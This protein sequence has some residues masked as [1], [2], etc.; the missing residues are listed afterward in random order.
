VGQGRTYLLV[1]GENVDATLG[2]S[3]LG[4]RPAADER[5]RWD[6]VLAYAKSIWEQP[7]TAL[8]FLNA[9]S[10][11]LPLG[12][13]QALLAMGYRPIPLSGG[14]H[15]KV[16]DIGIQRTLTAILER[17]GQAPNPALVAGEAPLTELVSVSDVVLASHDGDYLPQLTALVNNGHRVALL[18]FREFVNSSLSALSDH[19]LRIHDLEHDVKAFT[20]PLPRIRAIPLTQFDPYQYL[21]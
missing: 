10:G 7:V 1:D 20:V 21:V 4:H 14:D 18:G 13:I 5:P 8:F 15:E 9:T 6:A 17:G 11:Q 2:M 19:G 3:V 16:V 12:F